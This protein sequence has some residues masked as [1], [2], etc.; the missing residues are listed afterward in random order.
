MCIAPGKSYRWKLRDAFGDGLC[1]SFGGCGSYS[2]ALN[3]EEIV[4][5]GYFEK[6]VLKEIGPVNCAIDEDGYQQIYDPQNPEEI[7][8]ATCKGVRAAI[9]REGRDAAQVCGYPLADG[10]GTIGDRCKVVCAAEGQG[11]CA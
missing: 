7:L 4:S 2:V 1:S 6:E 9:K 8:S 11:P 10:S 3:G 5:N